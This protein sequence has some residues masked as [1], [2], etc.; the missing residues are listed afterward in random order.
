[1]PRPARAP[2][3][4]SSSKPIHSATGP[5]RE[6]AVRTAGLDPGNTWNL[7]SYYRGTAG[8]VRLLDGT[9]TDP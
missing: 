4:A 8:V 9:G 2:Q 5:G 3:P 6:D 7:L 1:M